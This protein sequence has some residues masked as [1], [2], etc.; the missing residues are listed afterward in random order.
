MGTR[1]LTFVYDEDKTLLNLYRQFDGYP[2]GHGVDLAKFLDGFKIVN[3]YGEVKPKIAN[4]MG[5]LAAQ[6]VAHFKESVGGFYIHAVTD[7][8]CGQDYEYHIYQDRVIIKDP[9]DEIFCGTWK[10]LAV[11]CSV[12]ETV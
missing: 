11:F 4:G 3:G 9:I 6:L 10:E 12:N 2:S 1:S 5:C 8:N 7:T